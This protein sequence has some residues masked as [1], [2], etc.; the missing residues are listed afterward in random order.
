MLLR[1]DA[2]ARQV[3]DRLLFE[4]VNLEIRAGDRIGL[5]GPNGAGKSTL[6]RVLAGDEETD[7][8]RVV[9]ARRVRVVAVTFALGLGV[10]NGGVGASLARPPASE[11]AVFTTASLSPLARL[12]ID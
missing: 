3:A 12:E 2:V 10:A 5:V 9:C 6:L 4:G 7:G 11:M 1:A 8:G